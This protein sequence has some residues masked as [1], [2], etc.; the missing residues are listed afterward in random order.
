LVEILGRN[1]GPTSLFYCDIDSFALANG[2]RGNSSLKS[3]TPRLSS[4]NADGSRQVL[5]IAGALK[6]NK[7]LVDLDLMHNFRMSDETWGAVCD[8]FKTHP[9]LEVLDLREIITDLAIAPA[10]ITA[11]ILAL[12]GILKMNTSIRL[13]SCSRRALDCMIS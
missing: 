6:E 10:T 2:L 11:R 13:N 5:A 9:T 12:L 4:N 1:Q 3:L 8:S 7:G